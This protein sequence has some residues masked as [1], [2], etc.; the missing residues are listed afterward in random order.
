ML[1][2]VG[3]VLYSPNRRHLRNLDNDYEGVSTYFV[4]EE[5]HS[6]AVTFIK[7]QI[8]IENHK[9]KITRVVATLLDRYIELTRS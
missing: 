1:G 6:R 5:R 7:N 9:N 3:F 2:V 4:T 8:I